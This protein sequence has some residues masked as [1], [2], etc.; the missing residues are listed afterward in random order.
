MT[1]GGTLAGEIRSRLAR[2]FSPRLIR[3]EDES[4]RHAGHREAGR[5]AHIRLEIA[6]QALDA[7]PLVAAHRRIHEALGPLLANGRIH[8]LSIRILRSR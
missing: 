8:A 2:A 3:I 4:W 7:L 1:D 6:A 5:G